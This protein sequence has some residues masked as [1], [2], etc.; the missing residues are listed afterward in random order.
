MKSINQRLWKTKLGMEKVS[1]KMAV[2]TGL[3]KTLTMIESVM[4]WKITLGK[5]KLCVLSV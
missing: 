3:K 5:F 4:V 2:G 1:W